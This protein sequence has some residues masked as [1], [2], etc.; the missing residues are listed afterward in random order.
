MAKYGKTNYIFLC[1]LD[2]NHGQNNLFQRP[3][4]SP[5]RSPCQPLSPQIPSPGCQ[6]P[7]R[8]PGSAASPKYQHSMYLNH[9]HGPVS[10]QAPI[11]QLKQ[12]VE[13]QG[14]QLQQIKFHQLKQQQ[15]VPNPAQSQQHK[16]QSQFRAQQ[17]ITPATMQSSQQTTYLLQQSPPNHAPPVRPANVQVFKTSNAVYLTNDNPPREMQFSL[18]RNAT[19][20]V[21]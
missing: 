15:Q 18:N 13:N 12:Q 7:Q 20:P 16:Q 5:G 9:Q 11:A 14:Q 2:K 1:I 8:S 17:R 21:G 4:P 3:L 6:S 10:S 19:N